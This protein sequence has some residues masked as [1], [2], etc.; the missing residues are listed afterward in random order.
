MPQLL[1]LSSICSSKVLPK[2]SAS[3][4]TQIKNNTR[5]FSF[6]FGG[7][8]LFVYFLVLNLV[9]DFGFSDT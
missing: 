9:D 5:V 3:T 1:F 4:E 7:S 2:L 8:F 6:P